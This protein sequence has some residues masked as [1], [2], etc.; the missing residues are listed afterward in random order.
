MFSKLSIPKHSKLVNHLVSILNYNY[1]K[2][3]KNMKTNSKVEEKTKKLANLKEKI[4]HSKY[5]NYYTISRSWFNT[6]IVFKTKLLNKKLEENTFKHSI[7]IKKLNS[8][9]LKE[10]D[11]KNRYSE[12]NKILDEVDDYFYDKKSRMKLPPM[13]KKTLFRL[14]DVNSISDKNNKSVL[15][16][17]DYNQVSYNN[18]KI[19]QE[20]KNRLKR[21]IITSI[22]DLFNLFLTKNHEQLIINFIN[23]YQNKNIKNLDYKDFLSNCVVPLEFNHVSH[24][25]EKFLSEDDNTFNSNLEEKIFN[26]NKIYICEG[27]KNL[28]FVH[29]LMI[30][31]NI[32][33]DLELQNNILRLIY[34]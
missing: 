16:N 13:K 26:L 28:T 4:Y 5:S 10:M 14:D 8:K 11:D 15:N 25:V 3:F 19:I 34:R 20:D 6:L 32:S 1:F 2:F 7:S 27:D 12:K 17:V 18:E 29:N 9:G 33:Q 24:Y 22:L 31:F 23:Y 21:E 30:A